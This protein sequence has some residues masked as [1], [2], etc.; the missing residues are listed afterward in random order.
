[1]MESCGS[2]RRRSRSRL[3]DVDSHNVSLQRVITVKQS[4][5]HLVNVSVMVSLIAV[6]AG[7]GSMFEN[8]SA[9]AQESWQ[10]VR[11]EAASREAAEHFRVGHL[12]KALAKATEAVQL[13]DRNV[14]ARI[15]LA[16]IHIE[17][18]RYQAAADEAD[19]VLG[20]NLNN[21]EAR[22]LQAVAHEKLGL[23]EY[24]LQDYRQAFELDESNF[25]A[26]LGA[27]EVLVAMD[28]P[29]DALAYLS[30]HLD[31]ADNDP[32][33]YELAGRLAMMQGQYD[34]AADHYRR[35]CDADMDNLDYLK[36]LG[37]AQ[38]YAGRHT[39][40]ARTLQAVI[41]QDEDVPTWVY[42]TLGDSY[43]ELGKPARA[44]EYYEKLCELAPESANSWLSLAKARISLGQFGGAMG[45]CRRAVDVD[46]DNADAKSLL[47]YLLLKDGQV[48]QAV[49]VLAPA[50]Q[51]H[52]D[53][54]ML[55]CVLGRAYDAAGRQ[56]R[57]RVCYNQAVRLDPDNQVAWAL[58]RG[59]L[60]ADSSTP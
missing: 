54:A 57:A 45:A 29:D 26:V 58:L 5:R 43:V 44:T 53:D 56:Q 23:L 40:A 32:A 12:D 7:C 47:G 49:A 48:D 13:S 2:R 4:I 15:I 46:A 36:A 39:Q 59:A 21:P 51:A 34:A 19:R 17:Q 27:S 1:M 8:A 10:D 60:I 18:G 24:A 38:V 31:L 37:L 11:A 22:F 14:N 9:D 42:A 50:V 3:T 55:Q 41:Q 6:L 16:K 25:S 35:A 52:P 28:R 20:W 33:A 30:R